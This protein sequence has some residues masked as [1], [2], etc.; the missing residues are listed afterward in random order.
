[1][2][3]HFSLSFFVF[4]F[5]FSFFITPFFSFSFFHIP[6]FYFL[7]TLFFIFSVLNL[8]I[9]SKLPFFRFFFHFFSSLFLR[10]SWIFSLSWVFHSSYFFFCVFSSVFH[11]FKKK[12]SVLNFFIFS[13]RSSVH[14]SLFHFFILHFPF[15]TLHFPFSFSRD[16]FFHNC[17]L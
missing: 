1:M 9:S 2:F 3:F 12:S 10:Y 17:L 6:F 4:G 15:S 13:I 16:P 14:F 8:F 5:H 11:S 7:S